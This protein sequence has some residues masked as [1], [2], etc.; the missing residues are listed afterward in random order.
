MQRG[1][2]WL[3]HETF[4]CRSLEVVYE[5]K[6]QNGRASAICLSDVWRKTTVKLSPSRHVLT[7]AL[8]KVMH[9]MHNIARCADHI[10]R[11]THFCRYKNSEEEEKNNNDFLLRLMTFF[12][13]FSCFNYTFRTNMAVVRKNYENNKQSTA[14]SDL[15]KLV[16]DTK[17]HGGKKT[18]RLLVQVDRS[19]AKS[20]FFTAI[21]NVSKRIRS[22]PRNGYIDLRS[23]RHSHLFLSIKNQPGFWSCLFL[24]A[25]VRLDQ[26]SNI[27]FRS[28]SCRW[29]SDEKTANLNGDLARSPKKTS[30][31]VPFIAN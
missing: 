25:I 17:S 3:R 8:H 15:W 19:K 4:R 13:I 27:L 11:N 20:F 21:S 23:P 2:L 5:W 9:T 30:N 10:C 28:R 24:L 16:R 29:T 31:L 18:M 7:R 26:F 22:V 1:R 6:H 14:G 12:H